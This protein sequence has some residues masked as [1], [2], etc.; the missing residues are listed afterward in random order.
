MVTTPRRNPAIVNFMVRL[1]GEG[2]ASALTG[3]RRPLIIPGAAEGRA[4]HFL[5]GVER[6]PGGSK[7]RPGHDRGV[8]RCFLTIFLRSAN[9]RNWPAPAS[10]DIPY[11]HILLLSIARHRI[12]NRLA[13]YFLP[14]SISIHFFTRRLASTISKEMT[15]GGGVSRFF[16]Q[17]S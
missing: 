9:V 2:P 17:R 16:L 13:A 6:R 5:A 14:V 7:M 8:P 11:V 4:I 10:R 3:A 12:S 1:R 15:Y